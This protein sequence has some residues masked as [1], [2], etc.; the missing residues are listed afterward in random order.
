MYIDCTTLTLICITMLLT[1]NFI[2]LKNHFIQRTLKIELLMIR[3]E[4]RAIFGGN[5][6]ILYAISLVTCLFKFVT[7]FSKHMRDPYFYF[8]HEKERFESKLKWLS[9]K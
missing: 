3:L 4:K 9:K 2:I 1:L 8:I 5:C 6:F 7:I